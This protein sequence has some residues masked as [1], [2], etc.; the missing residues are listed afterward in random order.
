MST[1]AP[2]QRR[3]TCPFLT[4]MTAIRRRAMQKFRQVAWRLKG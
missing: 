4:L 2:Q 3:A 1:P